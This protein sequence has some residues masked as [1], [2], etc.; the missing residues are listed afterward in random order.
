MNA[1]EVIARLAGAHPNDHVNSGQSSNDVIP[2]AMHI[3]AA[4]T[5]HS[6]LLPAME[7]LRE[8]LE[9]KAIEFDEIVK[10]GRTHWQDAAPV[11]LGQEFGGYARQ[12][13]AAIDHVRAAL[14]GI[15]ELP[16]GGT[17]VGTGLN[18]PHG[19]A[20]A[21]IAELASRTGLPLVE[22]RNHF[23][24]QSAKDAIV[25]LSAALRSYAIALMKIASDIRYLA[26]GPRCGIGELKAPEVQPG[27]SIMPGKVNP[28][29]AESLLMV[30][31]QVIGYDAT[32]AW[33]A[34]G[35]HLEL[36]VMMPVMAYDLLQS[37]EILAAASR[38]FAD[39]LVDGL[40]ADRER[41]AEL[42]ERSLAMAT[43]L[44]PE[45]GYDKTAEIVKEAYRSNRTVAEI[46][47]EKSGLAEEKLKEILDAKK[48]TT[49][50]RR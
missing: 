18:A 44:A 35:G 21:V 5:A 45:I 49:D 47:Q 15:Y 41:I 26:S 29:I 48:Q 25:F 19:F 31:A 37:E 20:Q 22:A 3:A 17:A 46:A 7:R 12:I 38:T 10:I 9:R 8:R 28:V 2:S 6:R 32:I 4:E 30:C 14:P 40:A 13:A 23:E 11:R 36:N 16:L 33:C 43:A 27:S 42:V 24:A 39:R 34:A 50:E 1:N